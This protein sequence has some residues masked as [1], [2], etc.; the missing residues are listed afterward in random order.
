MEEQNRLNV[1]TSDQMMKELE[2]QRNAIRQAAEQQDAEGFARF[3]ANMKNAHQQ[4]TQSMADA[5][6]RFTSQYRRRIAE[7]METVTSAVNRTYAE[8]ME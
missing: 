5:Q 6:N 4:V 1:K 8:G 2:R 3:A 7:S